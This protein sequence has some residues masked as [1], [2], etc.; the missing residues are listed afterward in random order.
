MASARIDRINEQTM[1]GVACAVVSKNGKPPSTRYFY[2]NP[3]H[4]GRIS[5][6][7]AGGP[8]DAHT[9]W[10][11]STG[12]HP[13][14]PH[15]AFET[16]LRREYPCPDSDQENLGNAPS[17]SAGGSGAGPHLRLPAS[18]AAPTAVGESVEEFDLNSVLVANMS[19]QAPLQGAA[20]ADEVIEKSPP[21]SP[22]R[23]L[24][25]VQHEALS[26]QLDSISKGM[27][28]PLPAL[29]TPPRCPRHPRLPCHAIR[30]LPHLVLTLATALPSSCGAELSTIR[31]S[32]AAARRE[33]A[34]NHADAMS[35]AEVNQA[36]AGQRLEF[37]ISQ[38]RADATSG[39]ASLLSGQADGFA[40]VLRGQADGFASVLSGQAGLKEQSAAQHGEQMKA[41]AQAA[42]MQDDI[43]KR[44]IVASAETAQEKARQAEQE[45]AEFEARRLERK[46]VEHERV[47][48]EAARQRTAARLAEV[49]ASAAE[50]VAQGKAAAEE[51][52]AEREAAEKAHKAAEH[53]QQAQQAERVAAEAARQRTAAGLAEVGASAAE[54]AA[55]GKAAAE[56]AG[57]VEVILTGF[58]ESV[59]ST[60]GAIRAASDGGQRGGAGHSTELPDGMVEELL[61]KISEESTRGTLQHLLL[62][63]KEN[64]ED[65]AAEQLVEVLKPM[66]APTAD[67]RSQ[68]AALVLLAF[69]T[70]RAPSATVVKTCVRVYMDML[71]KIACAPS[72]NDTMRRALLTIMTNMPFKSAIPSLVRHIEQLPRRRTAKQLK[73]CLALSIAAVVEQA[74]FADFERVEMSKLEAVVNDIVHDTDADVVTA[75]KELLAALTVAAPE[76]TFRVVG[77]SNKKLAPELAKVIKDVQARDV[78]VDVSHVFVHALAAK[79]AAPTESIDTSKL[80]AG[81]KEHVS[82]VFAVLPPPLSG[83][84]GCLPPPPPPPMAPPP[85][86]QLGPASA[87]GRTASKKAAAPPVDKQAAHLKELIDFVAKFAKGEVTLKQTAASAGA[88]DRMQAR[89][90]SESSSLNTQIKDIMAKRSRAMAG[91]SDEEVDVQ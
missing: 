76:I 5:A 25:A 87:A 53:E 89:G 82:K 14:K 54:A 66:I 60:L 24:S 88:I 68:E 46:A 41:L 6:T 83:M 30:A 38:S 4:F 35:Q 16:F 19:R 3:T 1:G 84:S 31:K 49:G 37:E 55:Q 72:S 2:Y 62:A 10:V 59:A 15:E 45:L 91:D 8:A 57:R 50:A 69:L 17:G 71:I 28:A 27:H 56:A 78:T 90:S 7:T 11:G 9:L 18:D 51:R 13:C 73:K 74:N 21:K 67:A 80:L 23:N 77:A 47:A 65:K 86:P 34:A 29:S 52:R 43:Q 44:M 26:A 58:S 61:S 20:L 48:A 22:L 36:L 12:R 40:S 32:Q 75:G 42:D 70:S 64:C 85:P 81:I 63:V 79:L 33:Q 39:F